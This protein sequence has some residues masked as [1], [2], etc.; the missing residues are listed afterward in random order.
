[1]KNAI[2]NIW[3]LGLVALFIFVFAGYL[4]VTISYSAAFKLKNEALT[5]IEKHKGMTDKAPTRSGGLWI[6]AG[7]M[8]T[9]NAYLHGMGYKV[10]GACPKSKGGEVWYG[11]DSLEYT[12][13]PSY[14]QSSGKKYY[15]CFSK[16]KAAYSGD[17][18]LNAYYYKVTFF[19]K[20]DLPVLGDIFTFEVPGTTDEIY[21]AKDNLTTNDKYK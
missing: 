18:T 3:L 1:M 21:Q 14:E 17:R 7:T 4:A 11:M 10:K 19:F 9:I 8:E 12:K 2:S 13:K 20:M 5:I 6:D 15:Y 16:Y